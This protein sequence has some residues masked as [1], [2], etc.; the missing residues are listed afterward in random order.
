MPSSRINRILNL[1]FEKTP[2]NISVNL[3]DNYKDIDNTN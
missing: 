3:P 2:T 1:P